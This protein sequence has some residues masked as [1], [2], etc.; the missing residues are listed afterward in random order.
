M[1]LPPPSAPEDKR[2]DRLYDYTKFHIG[3][4][5]TLGTAAVTLFAATYKTDGSLLKH[6]IGS[7]WLF[8]AGVLC[9]ALAGIAGG[10]IASYST[11][12]KTFDE[13]W[14]DDLQMGFVPFKRK[15]HWWASREHIAFW[16]GLF[17]IAAS[18]LIRG[19]VCTTLN[20]LWLGFRCPWV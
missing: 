2:L 3:I 19:G 16:V 12:K 11:Q 7:K 14:N 17:L 4:Y 15:G 1:W 6:L 20:G 18:F 5:L 9:I 10:V 13:L 8:L